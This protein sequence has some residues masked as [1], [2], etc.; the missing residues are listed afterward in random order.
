MAKRSKTAKNN[1][2]IFHVTPKRK[3]IRGKKNIWLST[4]RKTIGKSQSDFASMIGISKNVIIAIE[5]G[6]SPLHQK[7]AVKIQIAT[8]ASAYHFMT[9]N[10]QPVDPMGTPYASRHF[11]NWKA[12]YVGNKDSEIQR[13]Y[14]LAIDSLLL[15]L[16]AARESGR[17][18]NKL[19][20]LKQ[21]FGEWCEETVKHFG[22]KDI[23]NVILKR[24]RQYV[25][26]LT[27]T[28]K[29]WRRKEFK[30]W[31]KRYGFKDDK[32]KPDSEN[33][34]LRTNVAPGW[35]ALGDMRIPE[36]RIRSEHFI[37]S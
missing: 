9:G 6:R 35:N 8:G 11:E 37:L 14:E 31:G 26:E 30:N 25:A 27:M 17:P 24:D 36:N 29:E 19:P 33:L 2:P 4:I 32:S 15:I 34:T 16:L 7:L 18:K 12:N 23:L 1:Q 28:Y 22:L 5:N 10:D 3:F 20:A 13:F 21:S